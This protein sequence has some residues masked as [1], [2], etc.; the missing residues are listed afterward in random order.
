MK[1][2][3][4]AAPVFTQKTGSRRIT[5]STSNANFATVSGT[6][7]HAR[8]PGKVTVTVKIGND[9]TRS[10]N[11]TVKA[12]QLDTEYE[13]LLINP[14][15]IY[16]SLNLAEAAKKDMGNVSLDYTISDPSLGSVV[17]GIYS[18]EAAGKNT[19]T[20]TGGGMLKHFV[21]TSYVWSAHRGY[22]DMYPE[23]TLDA[24]IEAGKE[25]AA[26]CETD[27]QVTNDGRLVCL[28]NTSVTHMTDGTGSIHNFSYEE[29]RALTIDNGNGLKD[30]Q[31]RYIPDFEEYLQICSRYHMIAEIELK[32]W[33]YLTAEERTQAMRDVYAL[34]RKYG[35]EE[36]CFIISFHAAQLQSFLEANGDT[37]I[38]FGAL[39][40]TALKTGLEMNLPG[41]S[42]Y[43]ATRFGSFTSA[44]YSPR[45]GRQNLNHKAY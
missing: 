39:N 32:A 35:L 21:I 28:H 10:M 42:D 7:I 37:G 27:L 17:N 36:R 26:I 9:L 38:P 11:V 43:K 30:S 14:S 8:Y 25:G 4:N 3:E 34:I 12:K 1:V 13:K 33:A 23:N 15:R 16:T 5:L 19:V 29:A 24:F 20:V 2:G 6:T 22:L 40:N 41:F 31:Y 18:A 44:D 45:I